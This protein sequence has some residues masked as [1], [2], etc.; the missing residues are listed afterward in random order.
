MK[1]IEM[2]SRII[3]FL[4]ILSTLL[5]SRE[6]PF[7]SEKVEED[8]PISNNYTQAPD[9]FKNISFKL[10]NSSR[11]LNYIEIFYQNIDGS[12]GKKKIEIDKLFNWKERLHLGYN[13]VSK[14]KTPN[15]KYYTKRVVRKTIKK[16]VSKIVNNKVV[17]DRTT[18][19][20]DDNESLK[21]LKDEV[22]ITHY[23]NKKALEDLEN[24]KKAERELSSLNA[25][26]SSFNTS[27][28]S[29]VQQKVVQKNSSSIYGGSSVWGSISETISD[30]NLT[31]NQVVV[32]LGKPR[33]SQF[34]FDILTSKIK[35]STTDKKNRHFML[36]RPNRIVIDFV[37]EV[38]FPNQTFQINQ[39]IFGDMKVAKKGAKSYRVTIFIKNE[40]RYKLTRTEIGYNVKCF[41]P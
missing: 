15:S 30:S 12:I 41:K 28:N 37:R 14:C 19:V 36:I 8:I 13:L 31:G 6:N 21:G 1:V 9:H 34:A 33:F 39:G 10:P 23:M 38:S 35:V 18:T 4:L 16:R 40:Y 25:E 3:I 2:N 11:I 27:S 24:R 5:F 26:N 22:A 7:L 20:I 32:S 17:Y 29:K